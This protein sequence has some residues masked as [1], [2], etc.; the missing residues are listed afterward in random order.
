MP[1]LAWRSHRDATLPGRPNGPAVSHSG[2]DQSPGLHP[3]SPGSDSVPVKFEEPVIPA[4]RSPRAAIQ[5]AIKETP[6]GLPLYRYRDL[7]EHL[8]TLDR[9]VINF[10]GQQIEKITTPTPVQARAF[11]LLG[12]AVQVRLT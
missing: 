10:A 11:D 8:A 4:R 5:D 7:L 3:K 2:S 6:D 12:S 9:Q 1:G